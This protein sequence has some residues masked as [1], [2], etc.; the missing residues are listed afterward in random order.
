M[1]DERGPLPPAFYAAPAGTKRRATADWWLLLHVPYTLWHLSYVAIGAALSPRFDGTR[2][3]ATL[4]AF[5][6]AVGLGAHALDEL[7]GRP[8]RTSIP[9]SVLVAVAAASIIG[10]TAVGLAG[11]ARIGP[12][13]I[14]FIVLGV[15]LNCAYNLELFGGWLHNDITFAL[16]WGAFPLLT[17]FYA[18]A[19]MINVQAI[20]GGAFAFGLS[21]AQ[22]ALS[23]QARMLRRRV[24]SIAGSITYNDGRVVSLARPQL[25]APVETALKAMAWSVVALAIALVVH[26][27]TDI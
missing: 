21:A 1:T 9:S 18:Q 27:M 4:I 8:L 10:A 20:V 26:R 3:T 22:R 19:E 17:S 11:L 25:L 15:V 13:L 5:F 14:V 23:T 24:D 7:Q 2:L 6:L 12:G 16:A